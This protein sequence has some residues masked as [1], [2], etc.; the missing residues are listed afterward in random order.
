METKYRELLNLLAFQAGVL[1]AHNS[2]STEYASHY[3]ANV[4]GSE[5]TSTVDAYTCGLD[6][7]DN[8]TENE[9]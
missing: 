5:F 6:A 9:D 8:T 3:W 4:T 7:V 1:H 2:T